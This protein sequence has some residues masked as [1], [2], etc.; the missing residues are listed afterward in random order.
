M[1]I[2]K[3]SIWRQR[4]SRS[5]PKQLTDPSSSTQ[6]LTLAPALLVV[7]LLVPNRLAKQ[8]GSWRCELSKEKARRIFRSLEVICR[9][10]SSIGGNFKS[11]MSARIDCRQEATCDFVSSAHGSNIGRIFLRPPLSFSS[12]SVRSFSCWVST[13]AATVQRSRRGAPCPSWLK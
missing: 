3:E 2:R 9:G 8:L 10:L 4:F 5:L 7:S 1:L 12:N 13:G 11:G 6:K